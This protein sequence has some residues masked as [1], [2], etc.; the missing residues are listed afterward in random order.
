MGASL[1]AA[2]VRQARQ[3][4]H[5]ATRRDPRRDPPRPLQRPHRADQHPDPADRP[6]SVRIP[7]T[8]GAD[9]TR[10][11]QTRQP[12]PI[13]TALTPPTETSGDSLFGCWRVWVEDRR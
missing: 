6:T 8:T 4:D 5:R 1:P 3:N 13:V 2:T 11:A 7:L 12:L 10:D 9:R